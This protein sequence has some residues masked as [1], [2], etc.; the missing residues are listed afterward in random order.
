[1]KLRWFD[2]LICSAIVISIGACLLSAPSPKA[3]WTKCIHG[4]IFVDGLEFNTP[5]QL[6][7]DQ[8]HGIRCGVP[9]P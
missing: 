7:D 9:Q 2:W 3:H 5:Q 4:Y 8:G 6:L 1:M